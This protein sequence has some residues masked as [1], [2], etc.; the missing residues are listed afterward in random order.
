MQATQFDV[1]ATWV[2]SGFELSCGAS[3]SARVEMTSWRKWK[4]QIMLIT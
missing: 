2:Y 4:E 3:A 1:R